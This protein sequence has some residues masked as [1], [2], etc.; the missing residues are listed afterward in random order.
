MGKHIARVIYQRIFAAGGAFL[1][2]DS[3]AFSNVLGGL[4][5]EK[6]TFDGF[7]LC[8]HQTMVLKPAHA[9]IAMYTWSG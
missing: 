9:K 2:C 1:Q 7:E 6:G 8:R 5:R 3:P 4:G